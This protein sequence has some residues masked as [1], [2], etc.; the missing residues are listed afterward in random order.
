MNNHGFISL[1]ALAWFSFAM[2]FVSGAMLIMNNYLI[3]LENLQ[4]V[5]KELAVEKLAVAHAHQLFSE[6]SE[7]DY[8][9]FIGDYEV[10]WAFGNDRATITIDYQEYIKTLRLSYNWDNDCITELTAEVDK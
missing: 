4:I 3:A 1:V 10:C 2:T 7:E 5:E 9:D 6:V 8:C